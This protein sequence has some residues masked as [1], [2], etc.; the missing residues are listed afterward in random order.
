[1]AEVG[2]AII[3]YI[4]EAMDVAIE[5]KK[6]SLDSAHTLSEAV[7]VDEATRGG[8]AITVG[9]VDNGVVSGHHGGGLAGIQ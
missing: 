9:V 5:I 8:G 7:C 4:T 2:M 3:P 6:G 1:M